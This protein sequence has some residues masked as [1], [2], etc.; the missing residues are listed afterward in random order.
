MLATEMQAKPRD[1]QQMVANDPEVLRVALA[2]ARVSGV[3]RLQLVAIIFR[4][5]DFSKQ[6]ISGRTP[7]A[8]KSIMLFKYHNYGH[9]VL[10][11][12]Y[13]L[14]V[15]LFGGSVYVLLARRP[16]TYHLA[17][18]S[19]MFLLVTAFMGVTLGQVLVEPIVTST[20]A[21][22]GGV[23]IVPC[24]AGTSERVHEA[25]V[26]DLL[27]VVAAPITTCISL[28][29]DGVLIYRC[30]VLWPQRLGR[31]VGMA[32]GMLLLAETACGF[33]GAYFTSELYSLQ[34]QD[35]A[36]SE[37][38]PPPIWIKIAQDTDTLQTANYFLALAVNVLATIFI[39]ELTA[40]TRLME[41]KKLESISHVASRIWFV[42]RQLE[43]TLGRATGV[44]YRAAM[45][46]IIESGLLITASQ[47]AMACT[48]LV[49][50]VVIYGTI[51]Q[52]L[53]ACV[54]HSTL[55]D[56][57]NIEEQLRQGIVTL[58]LR[59]HPRP[60]AD[61]I[62]GASQPVSM[63][64]PKLLPH[65]NDADGDPAIISFTYW[66]RVMTASLGTVPHVAVTSGPM[67]LGKGLPSVSNGPA[68]PAASLANLREL[69][70]TSM[71][72]SVCPNLRAGLVQARTSPRCT[73]SHGS[74]LL[75]TRTTSCPGEPSQCA[76]LSVYTRRYVSEKRDSAWLGPNTSGYNGNLNRGTCGSGFS[77]PSS[78]PSSEKSEQL[79][80]LSRMSGSSV[81]A[82]GASKAYA[83]Q[84]AGAQ[85]S[86][87]VSAHACI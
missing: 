27:E 80:F 16:N 85:P 61:A 1:D 70:I 17:A 48:S 21:I 55:G 39:G 72:L 47:L 41:S 11:V 26:I 13:G 6:A 52:S 77:M 63:R 19:A 71:R 65:C 3:R 42:A 74:A 43:M 57:D 29:A 31:W 22:I 49:H 15:A 34:R 82:A 66:G 32:I 40:H 83:V 7:C 8:E 33:A 50:S 75:S 12:F 24:G 86:T 5:S 28:I 25:L 67:H 79:L 14:Y 76:C 30:V 38:T 9:V 46:M 20:S 59:P 37:G 68:A 35:T 23:I 87:G 69:H 54:S 51:F 78:G 62:A 81:P 84:S 4:S 53:I 58:L 45:S 18:S 60:E 36:S 73:A 10:S 2:D 56:S 64:V 44:R